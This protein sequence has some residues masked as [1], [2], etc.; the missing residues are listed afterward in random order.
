MIEIFT[1]DDVSLTWSMSIPE[2]LIHITFFPIF[3]NIEIL[4]NQ[5]S[6]HSF[7]KC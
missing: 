1:K 5:V 7:E 3:N 6:M 4:H 2:I